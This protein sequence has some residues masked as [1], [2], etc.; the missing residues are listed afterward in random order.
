LYNQQLGI[1]QAQQNQNTAQINNQNA[2]YNQLA[3][4]V[5]TGL[6]AANNLGYY[7]QQSQNEISSAYNNQGLAQAQGIL[8]SASALTS[9]LTQGVGSLVGGNFLGGSGSGASQIFN[10]LSGLFSGGGGGSVGQNGG[11]YGMAASSVDQGGGVSY[12]MTGG[13]A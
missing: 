11:N 6:T 4:T 1:A 3:G 5:G 10:G 12:P 9:G 8:G 2:Y 13:S 7:G